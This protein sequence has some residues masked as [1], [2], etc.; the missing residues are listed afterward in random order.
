MCSASWNAGSPNLRRGNRA[1]P[2]LLPV[3]GGVRPM[4]M[5]RPMDILHHHG[6]SHGDPQVAWD[7][8]IHPEVQ[9]AR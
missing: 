8:V 3:S 2:V 6:R 5:D 7:E 4:D 1:G 9:V